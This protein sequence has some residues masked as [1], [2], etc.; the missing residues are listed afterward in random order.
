MQNNDGNSQIWVYIFLA[1][2][3]FGGIKSCAEKFNQKKFI[4][5]PYYIQT[6]IPVRDYSVGIGC[7]CPYDIASDGFECG[8]RSAYT[9]N[10]GAE[11]QCYQYEKF[12]KKVYL[13]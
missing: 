8:G 12:F 10:G 2:M 1:I 13:K 4:Y 5:K 11:P 9:R 6:D 3:L 7:A